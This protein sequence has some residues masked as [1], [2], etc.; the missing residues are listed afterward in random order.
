MAKTKNKPLSTKEARKEVREIKAA[1]DRLGVQVDAK[2]TLQWIVAVS[3][4]ERESAF[5]QDA[6]TGVFGHRI[7]LMDFD[8]N[9]L[10][11][12]RHLAQ[13]A[14]AARRPNI[15]SAISIAGSS[16]QG[17]VQLFP[18]DCDFFERVN[19]KADTLDAA[20][21]TWREV[22]RETAL[23]SF[24]EPDIVLTEADFGFYTK[25]VIERGV[26]RAVGHPITWMPEDV[27]NGYITVKDETGAHLT[28]TWGEAQSGAGYSFL[29]WV[30]ADQ[31][32]CQ[33]A[34]VSNMIDVTWESPSG[35]IIALDGAIDSFFQEIYLEPEAEP[36]F[37]KII[38]H[39]DPNAM[40]SYLDMMR[41]QVHHYAHV[42]PNYGKVSKRLYNLFRL[43]DQLEAAA[44]IRELFDEPGARLYQVPSLLEAADAALIASNNVDRDTVIHQIDRVIGAVV[45]TTESPA[46][47]Q[48]VME[49]I[50]L[51]DVVLGRKL[52]GVNWGEVLQVVQKRC[53]EIVN[54]YFRARLFGF[55]HIK[56]FVES[57]KV[58][59]DNEE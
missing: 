36:I 52:E 2:K 1:A 13:R 57:L 48:M 58:R 14:R 4:A 29:A 10:D 5:A 51:R 22:F 25:P 12:F 16:A 6:Q 59:R 37:T 20:R 19:I 31:D 38:K 42:K 56:T 11:Y 46:R 50:R 54:E 18:G 49:L 23:R 17:K 9:E 27:L 28:I 40:K 15:E 21:Q 53:T 8:Q 30:V 32:A 55:P 41:S 45:E 34:L 43:T 3:A 44:Y 35:E 26:R 7:S 33:L 24:S 47:T 39:A